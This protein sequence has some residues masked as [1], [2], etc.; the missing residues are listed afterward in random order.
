[1]KTGYTLA[2]IAT[3]FAALMTGVAANAEAIRDCD[4]PNHYILSK[5]EGELTLEWAPLPDSLLAHGPGHAATLL[6][7]GR[8]LVVGGR[9]PYHYDEATRAWTT[10]PVGAEV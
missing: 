3:A 8:V 6:A 10:T 7:D 1:M 4:R 9:G 2:R 5:C